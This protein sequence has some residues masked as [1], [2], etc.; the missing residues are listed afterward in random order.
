MLHDFLVGAQHAAPQLGN[1]P[2]LS[3]R[4]KRRAVEGPLFFQDA[5]FVRLQ[6]PQ[7]VLQFF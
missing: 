5:H 4:P 7:P 2:T 6:L 3:S 1:Q